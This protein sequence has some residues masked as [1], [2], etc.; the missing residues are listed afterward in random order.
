LSLVHREHQRDELLVIWW[1]VLSYVSE[2]YQRQG[3]VVQSVIPH[4][5]MPMLFCVGLNILINNI[6][7][8]RYIKSLSNILGICKIDGEPLSLFSSRVKIY[9]VGESSSIGE[10]TGVFDC[11]VT[12]GEIAEG[13]GD[14]LVNKSSSNII[15]QGIDLFRQINNRWLTF[16]NDY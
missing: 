7:L 15:H 5:A 12:S 3:P 13:F 2:I 16:F 6:G 11:I 4:V 9:P 8:Y 10:S 1:S 14:Y